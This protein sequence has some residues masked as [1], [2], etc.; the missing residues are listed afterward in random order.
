MPVDDLP[1]RLIEIKP[2]YRETFW[3]R[4]CVAIGLAGGF[5]E[6]LEASAL[7]LVEVGARML[8]DQLP[9]NRD[10]MDIVAGKFNEK[11]T[12]RWKQVIAFLKLHYVLSR[13]TDTQYWIDNRSPESIPAELSELLAL[14]RSRSP[15]HRDETHVDEMFPSASY[16]YVLYGMGFESEP[17]TPRRRAFATEQQRAGKLFD[18]NRKMTDK[19]LANLPSNRELI[20]KVNQQGFSRI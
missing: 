19:L 11:F 14:W 7:V 5:L 8:A 18:S 17:S 9:A 3:H 6:P 15:W 4:N 2:G 16:Q 12:F 1:V 13:R 20:R 10:V